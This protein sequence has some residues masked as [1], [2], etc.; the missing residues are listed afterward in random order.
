MAVGKSNPSIISSRAVDN[1][2]TEFLADKLRE[3]SSPYIS[4]DN[5][6]AVM[7]ECAKKIPELSDDD[8]DSSNVGFSSSTTSR[9]DWKYLIEN[10]KAIDVLVDCLHRISYIDVDET[11]TRIDIE[12]YYV[13]ICCFLNCILLRGG[14]A[15]AAAA[16]EIV[17][18]GGFD[19]C[20]N[21]ME[22][23]RSN[24]LIQCASLGFIAC[25]VCR[26]V[27]NHYINS[28]MIIPIYK[29]I[30]KVLQKH[31]MSEECYYFACIVLGNCGTTSKS[32]TVIPT[33][34]RNKVVKRI[35]HGLLRHSDEA[36]SK[37]VGRRLLIDLVGTE[38]AM[39]M[40]G[41]VEISDHEGGHA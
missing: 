34:L 33:K 5:T 8:D 12:R 22:A 6:F 16:N 28:R 23:F 11:T 17:E 35:Y 9:I 19:H 20:L 26:V 36:R 13:R 29:T 31:E 1:E 10:E 27:D 4:L 40:F 15:D 41:A 7:T 24:V 25:L 2:K 14:S 32:S 21:I 38:D 18:K 37:A 3:L 30:A 39:K